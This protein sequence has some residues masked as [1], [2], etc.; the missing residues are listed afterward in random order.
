MPYRLHLNNSGTDFFTDLP[1][2]TKP[3]SDMGVEY[4][5]IH[6][7]P[8]GLD[9]VLTRGDGVTIVK[10]F[11]LSFQLLARTWTDLDTEYDRLEQAFSTTQ[12]IVRGDY[13][14]RI[15]APLSCIPAFAAGGKQPVYTVTMTFQPMYPMWTNGKVEND[16]AYTVA[17]KRSSHVACRMGA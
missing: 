1:N 9:K 4:R 14:R 5:H 15:S 6:I 3:S 12:N 8:A 16:T 7:Q 13:W 17:T 2:N 10:P 11:A